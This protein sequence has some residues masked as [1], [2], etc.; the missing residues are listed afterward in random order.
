MIKE[1]P[2]AYKGVVNIDV[3]TIKNEVAEAVLHK[4]VEFSIPNAKEEK[5]SWEEHDSDLR[6]LFGSKHISINT[7]NIEYQEEYY[8]SD[9]IMNNKAKETLFYFDWSD[10][11]I[12]LIIYRLGQYSYWNAKI[13]YV[14]RVKS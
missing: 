14:M 5:Q 10:L 6:M 2:S 3:E 11:S 1:I 12:T 8:V 4:L 7:K 9:Y 13:D